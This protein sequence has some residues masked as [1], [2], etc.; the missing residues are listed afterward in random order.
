VPGAA[1]RNPVIVPEAVLW[2]AS[3]LLVKLLLGH[4]LPEEVASTSAR[5]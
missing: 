2:F 1:F 5:S 3:V 4:V